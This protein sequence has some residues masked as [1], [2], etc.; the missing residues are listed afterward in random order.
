MRTQD[1]TTSM[2]F[3]WLAVF[4]VAMG[5]LEAIVVVYLRQIYY[6]QGFEF[7]LVLLSPELMTV[8]LIREAATLIMLAAVGIIAG[9][10]NLQ[11]LLYFLFSFAV[12]DILYYVA[13]KIFLGWPPSLMT[14]DL[15]FLIPITWIGPVLA[16]VI[17]SLTMI[18]MAVVLIPLQERSVSFRTSFYQWALVFLGAFM[19]LY[20]YLIDFTRLLKDSGILSGDRTPA[21][22]DNLKMMITQFIPTSYN[23]LLFAAGELIILA[24]VALMIIKNNNKNQP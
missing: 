22:E 5:F 17:C 9:R 2:K 13:L 6:P 12:W 14:W 1:S 4:A 10:N 15:L 16:P 11:R 19:I 3:A 23:W 24:G 7:P 8:E 21:E 18:L 20:T